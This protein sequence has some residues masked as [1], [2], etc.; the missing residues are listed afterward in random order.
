MASRFRAVVLGGTGYGGAEMI[1][2]LLRHPHVD[3]VRVTSIDDVGQP[4]GRVH[5]NLE[6]LTDL[7]FEDVPARAAVDGAD[8]ALLGLPHDVAL[9]VVPELAEADVRIVDMSAAFRLADAESYAERYGRPHPA[10]DLLEAFVYGLPEWNRAAIRGARYVANPGCF[11][12]CVQLGL[13][14]FARAGWLRGTVRTVAL[15]GSSGSGSVASGTT[16]HPVR[17]HNLKTYAALS[18]VQSFEMDEGL[19]RA[20]ATVDGLEFVPVSAP[21]SRGILATSFA[22]LEGPERAESIQDAIRA[23]YAEEP[24][25]RIPEARGPEVVAVQGGQYAEVGLTIGRRDGPARH[26]VVTSALDNLVKGGAGQAIQNMNLLLGL[27]ETTALT[28]PGVYP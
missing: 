11:A 12:T 21:L 17:S 15:T 2:R 5:P 26:V 24:F 16:H 6:G 23:A 28:E 10:P 1:R 8:V 27:E 25:V 20:G 22:T 9:E 7:V 19:R 14:P 4:L 3:L 13:L 18:H